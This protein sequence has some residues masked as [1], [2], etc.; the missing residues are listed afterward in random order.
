MKE[1]LKCCPCG[2]IPEG[3][4]IAESPSGSKFGYVSGYCCG[5]WEIEFRTDYN[6]LDTDECMKRAVQMWN[7]TERGEWK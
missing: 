3:L 1:N 4:G 7:E 5:M 2:K 6:G